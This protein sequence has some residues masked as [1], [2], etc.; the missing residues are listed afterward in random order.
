MVLFTLLF[1]VAL[2]FGPVN[3]VLKRD[4]AFKRKLLSRNFLQCC[5]LRPT[6]G[7]NVSVNKSLSVTFTL[8]A[9]EHYVHVGN[10]ENFPSYAYKS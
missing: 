8:K 1:K 10:T 5:L 9:S 3:E 7:S 4:P 6:G 2:I